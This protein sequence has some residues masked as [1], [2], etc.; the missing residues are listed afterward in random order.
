MPRPQ[1][2]THTDQSPHSTE[3]GQSSFTLTTGEAS[4]LRS[5]HPYNLH[6]YTDGFVGKM[7][8]LFYENQTLFLMSVQS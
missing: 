8:E 3:H 6:A 5:P 2:G 4:P 7:G 1:N